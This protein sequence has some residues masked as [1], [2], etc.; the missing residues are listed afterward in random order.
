MTSDLVLRSLDGHRTV[1]PGLM[2]G[3]VLAPN[4]G[5]HEV[6]VSLPYPADYDFR[7]DAW[8]MRGQPRRPHEIHC[9]T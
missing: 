4:S 8:T 3:R 5:G 7:A 2:T 9:G 6:A 1:L